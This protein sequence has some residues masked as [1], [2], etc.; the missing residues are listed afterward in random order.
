MAVFFDNDRVN[1]ILEKNRAER[2]ASDRVVELF[3]AGLLSR[4]EA[5]ER[6]LKYEGG[7]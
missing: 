7:N 5:R 4:D 2:E 3:K 6:V 1:S